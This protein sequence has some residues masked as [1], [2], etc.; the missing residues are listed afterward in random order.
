ME[1]M[2]D[3]FAKKFHPLKVMYLIGRSWGAEPTCKA[4]ETLYDAW[5]DLGD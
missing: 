4:K 2:D 3:Y 5:K 1:D